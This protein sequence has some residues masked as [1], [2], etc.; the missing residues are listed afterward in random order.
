MTSGMVSGFEMKALSRTGDPAAA[1]LRRYI[2]GM[3]LDAPA[4]NRILWIVHDSFGSLP[5]VEHVADRE[6][7]ATLSLLAYL[8]GQTHDDGV[9]KRIVD[10]RVFVLD[11]VAKL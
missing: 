8:D 4:M 1:A 6:P 9:R 11:Q 2:A 7:T 5:W 3:S 10:E